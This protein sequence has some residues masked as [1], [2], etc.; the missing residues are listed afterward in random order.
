MIKLYRFMK[1]YGQHKFYVLVFIL[2][3][4][5][6]LI[7]RGIIHDL[8]KLR[9][10]ER[11]DFI[12]LANID[13]TKSIK[14]G[15]DE[16][17]AILKEHRGALDL[18]YKRNSHH[19]EHHANGVSQMSIYD[20]IEMVCDWKAAGIRNKGGNLRQSFSV[21]RERYKISDELFHILERTF[22]N[23]ESK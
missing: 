14:Y 18:H 11:K 3:F 20:L 1:G 6:K 23:I 21:N 13:F 16:Y 4:A 15:S 2:V 9:D 19:K 17:K 7:W 12:V 8:S 10:D 22:L 5:F